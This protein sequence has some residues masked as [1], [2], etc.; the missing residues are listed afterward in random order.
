MSKTY[1]IYI[2]EEETFVANLK[3]NNIN[4]KE[5]YVNSVPRR[6][7]WMKTDQVDSFLLKIF[8][9]CSKIKLYPSLL[10]SVTNF[11]YQNVYL[12]NENQ[13]NIS[14]ISANFGSN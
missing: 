4:K 1:T 11:T 12:C 8:P 14:N 5:I 13:K 2:I 3:Y 7:R 6:S 9:K 10:Y